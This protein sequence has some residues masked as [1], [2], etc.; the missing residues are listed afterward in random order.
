VLLALQL[1]THSALLAVPTAPPAPAVVSPVARLATTA[2]SGVRA[3]AKCAPPVELAST[4]P[5][6][7]QSL[8]MPCALLALPTVIPAP[9]LRMA[10]ARH[11]PVATSRILPPPHARLAQLA[12]PASTLR[13]LALPLRTLSVQLAA[14]AALELTKPPPALRPATQCAPTALAIAQAALARTSP[15]ARIALLATTTILSTKLAQ[16]AWPI[17]TSAT[18]R[19]LTT[20]RPAMWASSLM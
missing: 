4:P 19:P 1:Q 13:P 11:A 2:T 17:A 15:T 6:P 8:L 14:S 5:Q 18:A 9:V 20:A 3:I 10:L 12:P 16:L 7:A